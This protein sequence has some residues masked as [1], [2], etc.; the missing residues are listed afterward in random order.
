MSERPFLKWPGGKFRLLAHIQP[1]FPEGTH[2][3]EPFVGAGAVFL[4]T[5]FKRYW[6]NDIN[7]D[8]INVYK[9]L[10]RLGPDFIEKASGYFTASH[11]TKSTYLKLRQTF[12]ETE[13]QE[14]RAYLFLYLNRHG[15]NGLCRYNLKGRYNVPFGLYKKPYFPEKE[16]HHFLKKASRVRLFNQ[17]YESFLKHS[18]KANQHQIIYCDPPYAPISPTANFT[19]Y[20]ANRFGLDQ[21]TELARMAKKLAN[22]GHTVIIS[23]HDLPLTRDLYRDADIHPLNVQRVISCKSKKRVQVKELIAVFDGR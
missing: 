17:S 5:S 4:N 7:P 16:L 8:L 11:N 18:L 22:Q 20:S 10:K 15:Y 6:I 3:C 19:S 21:Q 1:K 2:L 12:N 14:L 9:T 13:D 23:N